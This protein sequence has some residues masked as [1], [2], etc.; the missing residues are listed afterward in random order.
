MISEDILL[1]LPIIIH[2]TTAIITLF[3]RRH[4]RW[5]RPISV[6]GGVAVLA[7]A[8]LLFTQIQQYGIRVSYIGEWVAPYGITLVADRLSGIMV[9]LTSIIGLATIIYSLADI[10]SAREQ[11][12]YHPLLHILL[13]GICG[14]FLTG[15]I[16][17]LYVWFEVLLISS[18]VLLTLGAS[19][20]QLLGGIKYVTLNLLSSALFL[21]A[22]SMLYSV[23][24]TLNMAHISQRLTDLT[25]EPQAIITII[26]FLF[27]VAFGLKSALFPLY[28]WLP[29]SY[30]TPP[31][32]I[33][34]VFAGLLTK[35]GVYALLRVFTLIFNHNNDLIL[36][37]LLIMSALTMVIAILG[38][39]IQTDFRRTLSFNLI[40]HIGYMVMGLALFTPLSIAGT[41]FYTIHHII[42]KT[43]LFLVSGIVD[44]WRGTYDL[45]L[46]GDIYRHAPAISIMF[47]IPALSLSGIPPLSGFWPKVAL[48]QAALAAEQY[49]LVLAALFTSLIT[50]YSMTHIWSEAFW[51]DRPRALPPVE[52]VSSQDKFFFFFPVITLITLIILIGLFA[53]P[54]MLLAQNTAHDLL[55]P[56]QYR[57]AVLSLTP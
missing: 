18:F 43:T 2:L 15:D 32:A 56:E 6:F 40:S 9:L 23:V 54:I 42:V 57:Q 55:N 45:T 37:V 36:N 11:Y 28:A 14:A 8:L 3:L 35:V 22:A 44:R 19:Q 27:L 30:H 17:N 24:G 26:S 51:K 47:L 29:A 34:A 48:L 7:S 52:P 1:V 5:H 13:M 12:G 46:L 33:S 16:F 39:F 50:L 10:D 53:N 31:A 21:A 4:P 41:I 49:L 25:I 38:T 20:A